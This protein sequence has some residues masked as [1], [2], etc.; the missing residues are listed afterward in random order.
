VNTPLFD[1]HAH[2]VSGDW[3]SY[4]PRP[5]R[6]D[7]PTRCAQNFTVTANRSSKGWRSRMC[8]ACLVQRGHLY[9]Y[10]NS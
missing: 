9:G 3:D 4:P 10:D 6:P 7:L 5:L 2:L 1:T 8:G